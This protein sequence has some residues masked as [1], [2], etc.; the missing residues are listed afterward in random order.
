LV[1]FFRLATYFSHFVLVPP[2]PPPF[3]YPTLFRSASS[4][5][6]WRARK[7]SPSSPLPIS[8]SFMP[9]SRRSRN[10][11]L[12]LAAA[13]KS[14]GRRSTGGSEEHTSPLQPLTHNPFR[15]LLQQTNPTNPVTA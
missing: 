8:A 6:L 5:G 2:T 13:R 11:P 4:A 3:A 7:R 10:R 9:S 14:P 15:P 12:R 1:L